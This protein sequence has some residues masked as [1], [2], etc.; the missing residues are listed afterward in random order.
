MLN[1]AFDDYFDGFLVSNVFTKN[2]LKP[3]PLILD[4]L[5][6]TVLNHLYNC[7]QLVHFKKIPE[8]LALDKDKVTQDYFIAELTKLFDLYLP[9]LEGDKLIQ[10][11]ST[12]QLTGHTDCYLKHIICLDT[13]NSITNEEMITFE[14]KDIYL[15][16]EEL[17]NDLLRYEQGGEAPLTPLPPSVVENKIKDIKSWDVPYRKLQCQKA[18]EY[19]RIKQSLTDHAKVIVEYY[20]NE[21]D[22]LLAWKRLIHTND[23]DLVIG[24]NIFGFDFKFLNDRATELGCVEEFCQLG[25]IKGCVDLFYEQKLS[26]AGLGDNTLKYIPMTGRIIIDLYKVIQKDYRL[27]SYKLDSVCHKFLYKEK[28]DMPPHEIFSLQKGNANDRKKI[29]IYCLIDC[30]LCNRL[31]LK[32]WRLLVTIWPWLRFVK[33]RS[34]IFSYGVKGSKFSVWCRICSREGFLIPVLPKADP[35]NDEKYEGAIV[36]TPETKI[37]FRSDCGGRFQFTVS[38]LH[39]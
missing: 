30:I 2:N 9:P 26:S 38:V 15:P 37:F 20:D 11:G 32:N 22:I 31:I 24:Y 4:S 29:A 25:R 27:D 14:N 17:A 6:P 36:L 39:D 19:R 1:L 28:V 5:V 8:N 13:T 12:F 7:A 18:A 35:T 10:I 3:D 23:P 21:R 33:C 34:P 16:V